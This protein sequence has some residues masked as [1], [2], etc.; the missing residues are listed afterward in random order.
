MPVVNCFVINGDARLLGDSELQR[1]SHQL[2]RSLHILSFAIH[3]LRENAVC[4]KL[5]R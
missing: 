3:V 5:L 1:N 2:I 4:C